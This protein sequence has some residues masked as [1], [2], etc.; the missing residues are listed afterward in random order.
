MENDENERQSSKRKNNI[1]MKK[2]NTNREVKTEPIVDDK[3]EIKH[4]LAGLYARVTEAPLLQLAQQEANF[5]TLFN[6]QRLEIVC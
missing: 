4:D 3:P 6:E 2:Q 5:Q 1:K